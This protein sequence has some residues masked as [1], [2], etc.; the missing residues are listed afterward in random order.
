MLLRR[1]A[2]PSSSAS[3]MTSEPQAAVSACSAVS[4]KSSCAATAAAKALSAAGDCRVGIT[5][6]V[7][8]SAAS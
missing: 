8:A 5:P 1:R 7:T 3:A 6:E 2:G 4:R